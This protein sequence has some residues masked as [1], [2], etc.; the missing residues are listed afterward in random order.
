MF[1][2]SATKRYVGVCVRK[3]A[4]KEETSWVGDQPKDGGP[5]S[6]RGVEV[7]TSGTIVDD[8][9]GG[10]T[11]NLEQDITTDT[12]KSSM[13]VGDQSKVVELGRRHKEK[14]DHFWIFQG[15]WIR[16]LYDLEE[17]KQV[18][19]RMVTSPAQPTNLKVGH[20]GE[21]EGGGTNH[22]RGQDTPVSVRTKPDEACPTMSVECVTGIIEMS[23][24]GHIG[25]TQAGV[26]DGD[27]EDLLS[28]TPGQD[29]DLIG[30][31]TSQE[32]RRV[33]DD[34]ALPSNVSMAVHSMVTPSSGATV[35]G[36]TG[37]NTPSQ[38]NHSV[39]S[40][41]SGHQSPVRRCSYV[42]DV[43]SIHGGGAKQRWRPDGTYVDED[44]RLVKKRKYF[45]VCDLGP[46]GGGRRQ[47]RFSFTPRRKEDNPGSQDDTN[48]GNLG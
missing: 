4:Q 44:G 34:R 35:S 17:D 43:C 40:G 15:D 22:T 33:K 36:N 20:E 10:R 1:M 38:N 23:N 11:H 48:Q 45:Y 25:D 28:D 26:K 32:D 21:R 3:P 18:L 46:N 9:D 42:K 6:P 7:G 39:L 30:A 41:T 24:D 2:Q 27:A 16:M 47:T 37:K 5:Q 13:R 31:G 14:E 29:G 19:M 12:R 8:Q